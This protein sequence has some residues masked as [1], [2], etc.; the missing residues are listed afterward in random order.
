ME[1]PQLLVDSHCHIDFPEF[2]EDLEVVLKCAAQSGVGF[3]LCVSV[4]MEHFDKIRALTRA[5]DHIFSS[6]GTHPNA[7]C[8]DSGEPQI[9]D[10]VER[11]RDRAV[12][13]IGETGLDYFRSTGDLEWQRNRFRVHIQ[14][15]KQ[16]QLPLIVHSRNAA[17]QT[18]AILKEEGAEECGGVIHCFTEDW[19]MASAALDL[20]FYISFSGIVTF[21]NSGQ[22]Q[23]VAQRLPI[24][25]LLLETDSPYLAPVPLRGKR[26]QPA[27]VRYTAEFVAELRNESIH[28]IAEQTTK[29]FFRLFGK[30][31]T[32]NRWDSGTSK[33]QIRKPPKRPLPSNV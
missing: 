17:D 22:I 33:S 6:I 24:E 11:S 2:D 23:R 16:A 13:A 10:L 28:E 7:D 9:N 5:H 29:N 8:A 27:F 1:S 4:K 12:V 19:D 26:N 21:N 15:A 30:A 31:A 18:I 25:R 20:G 32:A 3:L 14:A